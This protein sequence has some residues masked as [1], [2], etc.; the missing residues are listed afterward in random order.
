MVANPH[1]FAGAP[2]LT[3]VVFKYFSSSTSAE[4]ALE[5]GSV[6]FLN[7]VPPT[8]VPALSKVSK[9]SIGTEEDQSN[10][11]LI[12][13]MNANLSDGSKNPVSNLLV[14]KAIAMAIYLPTILNAT[15][16]GSQYYKL[17]QPD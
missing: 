8:D 15:F 14:R 10:V 1:Y 7:G 5:S 4:I 17:S 6:N 13:N 9:V 16:G 11:Y 12:F 3:N 2:K